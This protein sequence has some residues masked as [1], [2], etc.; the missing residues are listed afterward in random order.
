MLFY[1]NIPD[2]FLI[3]HDIIIRNHGKDLKQLEAEEIELKTHTVCWFIYLCL[4]LIAI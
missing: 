4:F 1:F 3:Y 2:I